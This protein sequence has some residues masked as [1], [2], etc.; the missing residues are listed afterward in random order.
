MIYGQKFREIAMLSSLYHMLS[1][2]E[3][4]DRLG[5]HVLWEKFINIYIFIITDNDTLWFKVFLAS[6][7]KLSNFDLLAAWAMLL[8]TMEK[9]ISK[10]KTQIFD[11]HLVPICA[12]TIV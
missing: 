8:D 12:K 4:F 1:I 5:F 6:S 10:F 3:R 11:L 9:S 2:W 7:Y